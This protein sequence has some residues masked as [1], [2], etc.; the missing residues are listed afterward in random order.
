MGGYEQRT[1]LRGFAAINGHRFDDQRTRCE[2]LLFDGHLFDG[3]LRSTDTVREL[4][5]IKGHMC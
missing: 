5:A 2:G 1:S 3:F 4:C